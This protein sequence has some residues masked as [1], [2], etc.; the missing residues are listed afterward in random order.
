MIY[1]SRGKYAFLE[2]SSGTGK[3][4]G[5]E[6]QD[7]WKEMASTITLKRQVCS[8]ININFIHLLCMRDVRFIVT[9]ITFFLSIRILSIDF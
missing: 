8:L 6:S 4:R 3:I 7:E 5:R 9:W 2:S 1:L